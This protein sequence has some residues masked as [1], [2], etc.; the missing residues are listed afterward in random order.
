MDAGTGLDNFGLFAF[1]CHQL[2]NLNGNISARF[3]HPL[4]KWHD[5]AQAM[6]AKLMWTYLEY[7][8]SWNSCARNLVY[9]SGLTWHL[10]KPEQSY[11]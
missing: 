6:F 1:T 10:H 5:V 8:T 3:S 11:H 9:P 2:F 4:V 7:G